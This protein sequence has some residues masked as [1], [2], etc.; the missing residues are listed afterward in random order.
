MNVEVQYTN[1]LSCE[2]S[3]LHCI[4]YNLAFIVLWDVFRVSIYSYIVNHFSIL[5][6]PKIFIKQKNISNTLG[7]VDYSNQKIFIHLF[8]V[9]N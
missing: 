4:Y 5:A 3:Q 9:K 6:K 2:I 1:I 8:F 7:N